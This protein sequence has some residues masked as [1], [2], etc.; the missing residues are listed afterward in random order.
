MSVKQKLLR[1]G[2][3]A[4]PE[5]IDVEFKIVKPPSKLKQFFSICFALFKIWLAFTIVCIVSLLTC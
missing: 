1:G 2:K 5:Y 3:E 4:A